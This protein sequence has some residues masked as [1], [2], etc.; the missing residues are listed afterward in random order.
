MGEW[1]NKLLYMNSME[2]DSAI[3]RKGLMYTTWINLWRIIVNEKSHFQKV[4][5]WFH[6]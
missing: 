5:L 1:L 2:Y 3:K 6:L 4:V